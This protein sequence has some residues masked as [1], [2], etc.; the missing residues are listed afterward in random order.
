MPNNT[1]EDDAIAIALGITSNGLPVVTRPTITGPDTGNKL[2]D[3]AEFARLNL[4]E[5]LQKSAEASDFMM[6]ILKE[7]QHPRAAEVLGQLLKQQSDTAMQMLDIHKK[8]KDILES[9][10]ASIQQPDVSISNAVFVGTSSEL[11]DMLRGKTHKVIEHDD[12]K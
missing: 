10:A 1:K 12:L 6:N 3:D 7:S 4:H 8:L 11:L 9:E 5:V 2:A